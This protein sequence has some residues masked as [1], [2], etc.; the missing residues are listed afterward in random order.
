MLV[1]LLG[2]NS[3][4]TTLAGTIKYTYDALG[5]LI[6]ENNHIYTYDRAGN[7]TVERQQDPA[8]SQTYTYRYDAQGNT[9]S[10]GEN[11]YLYD[12]LNHITEVKTKAG[13][14]QKKMK[15]VNISAI[16]ADTNCLPPTVSGQGRI[17]TMHVMRCWMP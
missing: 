4:K 10:D 16:S 13:D 11:T 14:I 3:N 5:Q 8:G 7:R 6:Q 12:C 9:L 17:I 1:T 2:V 15:L